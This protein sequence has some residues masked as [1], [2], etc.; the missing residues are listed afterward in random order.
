[1]DLGFQYQFRQAP[2][3]QALNGLARV[4]VG[5]L[6]EA[7]GGS[8]RIRSQTRNSNGYPSRGSAEMHGSMGAVRGLMVSWSA[9]DA[10]GDA[11][12]IAVRTTGP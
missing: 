10:R 3:V 9:T 8:S 1:M 7:G 12:T 11:L 4:R 6:H 2:S 5:T